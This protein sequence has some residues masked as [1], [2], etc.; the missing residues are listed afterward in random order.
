M[1]EATAFVGTANNINQGILQ[2]LIGHHVSK[3]AWRFLRWPDRVEL[4]EP[5]EAID[6]SCRE[7]QV[8]NQDCELRW[9]RQGDHYSVLLLS[10]AEN[11]EGEETLAGVGNNWTAE[12]RNANFYPPTETR[13]PRG[14]AY[15]EKLDIGQRYF[16]DKDTGTVHFIALRVK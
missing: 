12:E 3:Q 14:L 1:S 11:S 2:S 10:V 4:L 5:T 9:K 7:G 15:S 16:I 13:F 6:Y 8:F